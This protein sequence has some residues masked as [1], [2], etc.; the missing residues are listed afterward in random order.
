QDHWRRLRLPQSRPIFLPC[1]S[2]RT[3]KTPL[4]GFLLKNFETY[5]KVSAEH[6]RSRV[7]EI[8]YNNW[9][10]RLAL[11]GLTADLEDEEKTKELRA[12]FESRLPKEKKDLNKK[13][14]DSNGITAEQL[15]NSP[16][17]QVL[18]QEYINGVIHDLVNTIKKQFNAT[19]IQAWALIAVA[20]GLI[21]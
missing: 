17:Y 1:L 4:R 12:E 19:D 8:P 11:I 14:A 16:N 3:P 6:L 7:V 21:R 9:E 20:L 10:L 5:D 15:I 2:H 18:H 13:I